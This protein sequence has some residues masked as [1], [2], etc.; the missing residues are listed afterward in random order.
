MFKK[1]INI[2]S[3]KNSQLNCELELKCSILLWGMAISLSDL[4]PFSKLADNRKLWTLTF[5]HTKNTLPEKE[6]KSQKAKQKLT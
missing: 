1:Q 4:V 3:T 5:I 6:K 2:A